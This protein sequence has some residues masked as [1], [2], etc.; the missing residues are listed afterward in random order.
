MA[1]AN[2]IALLFQIQSWGD[3]INK[4]NDSVEI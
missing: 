3:V 4:A 1:Y 2:D